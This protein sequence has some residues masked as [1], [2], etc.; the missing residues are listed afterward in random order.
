MYNKLMTCSNCNHNR[1]QKCDSPCGC[2]APFLG[3]EQVPDNISV[4]RFSIDG[5]RA[6][7]DYTNLIYQAQSDTALVADI[8]NRLLQYTAERHTDTITAREL[9]A[10]LHLSELGDV[11]TQGAVDG[12]MLMYQK[13]SNCA[14][15]C[16]GTMDTWKV[17]NSLDEQV[18]SATYPMAFN[19]NGEAVTIQRPQNPNKQYLLGWNRQN[20]LSYITPMKATT[21]PAQGGPL[22]YDETSGQIVYVENS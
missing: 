3:I 21:P 17:W 5:K 1:C 9:G 20:Q 16:V 7:Y 2:P 19:A 15:G 13:S 12:S 18:S 6:D 10:L 4:L 22:Y 14:E 8:V 11:T